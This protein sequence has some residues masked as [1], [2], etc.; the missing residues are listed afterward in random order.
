MCVREK[1]RVDSEGCEIKSARQR[2]PKILLCNR[3][4][5]ESYVVHERERRNKKKV[6]FFSSIRKLNAISHQHV[7]IP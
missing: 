2:S 6:F 1:N 4:W 7:N 5:S 3:P